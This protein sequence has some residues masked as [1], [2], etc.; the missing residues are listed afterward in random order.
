ME[1]QNV[2]EI[3]GSA[4]QERTVGVIDEG[5]YSPLSLNMDDNELNDI[6]GS[7]LTDSISMWNSELD[8]DNHRKLNEEAYLDTLEYPIDLYEHQTE[9]KNN[10]IFTAIETLIPLIGA[11]IPEPVVTEANDTDA[12]R[13]LAQGIKETLLA[14]YDDLNLKRHFEMV[15][16]HLYIGMRLGVMKYRWDGDLGRLNENGER[17]GGLAVE[18][19]RPT[20]IVLDQYTKWSQYDDVPLIGEYQSCTLEELSLKFPEKKDDLVKEFRRKK[21]LTPALSAN[22]GYVEAWATYRGKN[23]EK[24]EAVIWKYE[25]LILGSSKNPHYNYDEYER[26]EEGELVFLNFFD[27][28]KKPYIFF[29]ML[30]TGKYLIDD[31]SLTEQALPMQKILYKR[32]FQIVENSDKANTGLVFNSQMIDEG[33]VSKLIGDPDEKVMVDGDVNQAAARLPMNILPEYVLR[34]KYDARAE[35]DN[36]FGATAPLRG[37]NSQANTLGQD[38]M[39]Q[40]SNMSRVQTMANALETGGSLLYQGLV[41]MIKIFWD[42]PTQVKHTGRDGVTTHYEFSNDKIEDGVVIRVKSGSLIPRDEVA[43]MNQ[44]QQI[45]P[46]LDPLTLAEGLNMKNPKKVA[47][48]MIYYRYAI[49]K[50]LSEVLNLGESGIDR[51]AVSDI[52]MINSGAIIPIREEIKPEYLT[53]Y[54]QYLGSEQFQQLD[55]NVKQAHITFIDKTKQQVQIALKVQ[56][57]Q[58]GM[59]ADSSTTASPGGAAPYQQAAETPTLPMPG[60]PPA[61]MQPQPPQV[62]Q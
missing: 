51:D 34:D 3:E 49:D 43:K 11:Q 62:M 33:D 40:R 45:A 30:N 31:T 27:R 1:P 24:Q 44:T 38:V 7:R 5:E 23:G 53:T 8:L 32:G 56:A 60:E 48:R 22:V 46:T 54:A 12:S 14:L 6:L 21:K 50:Y 20:R 36:A 61:Q 59:A 41:Q 58:E 37:E 26:N 9:Y 29:N 47:T 55:D 16:R 39:A 18:T 25:D 28:P 4:S 15:A 13:E 42:E 52:S 10:R 35:I 19:I 17:P 2:N 57:P